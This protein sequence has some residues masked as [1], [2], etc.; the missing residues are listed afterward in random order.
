MSTPKVYQINEFPNSE[1]KFDII[2][3]EGCKK[4]WKDILSEEKSKGAVGIINLGYFVLSTG[5]YASDCKIHDKWMLHKNTGSYGI[6]IDKDGNAYVGTGEDANAYSY[7]EAVPA[8]TV[9]GKEMNRD[10][11]WS[12]NGTT[13]LGF[14]DG[15]LVCMLCDKDNGQS[16][17]NQIAS[18]EEYGCDTILRMD[19][20]WSSHGKLGYGKN[21]QPSQSRKDRFYLVIYDKNYK[22]PRTDKKV[23]LDPFGNGSD[24]DTFATCKLLKAL[25]EDVEGIE[26]M[27]SR[28]EDN[29]DLDAS[30]RADQA[31]Q[32]GA[33]LVYS[34]STDATGDVDGTSVAW[35]NKETSSAYKFAKSILSYMKEAGMSVSE[36]PGVLDTL[37]ILKETSACAALAL[38][39]GDYSTNEAR[40]KAAVISAKAI[41]NQLG[42][43]YIEDD[44]VD[45]PTDEPDIEESTTVNK[46]DP[47]GMYD[48]ETLDKFMELKKIGLIDK[49]AQ[50]Q[51]RVRYGDIL[52]ALFYSIQKIDDIEDD[53]SED[54]ED[55]TP[56]LT[57]AVDEEEL[58]QFI[59]NAVTEAINDRLS[60]SVDDAIT[61]KLDKINQASEK[62]MDDI[63]KKV[64]EFNDLYSKKVEEFSKTYTSVVEDLSNSTSSVMN[65]LKDSLQSVVDS[66]I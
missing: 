31:N 11:T 40:Y 21:V 7:A 62:A 49:D 26:C 63:G 6:C 58:K 61:S 14:K 57:P 41:C 48:Q 27:I 59:I 19:G 44:T 3:N 32:W 1:Y 30:I 28:Y 65:K 10:Q 25:L 42:V 5:N 54:I 33:N 17:A 4:S 38:F 36:T 8:Y 12:A 50:I 9:N 45:T 56:E 16:T 35:T 34:I 23:T 43:E 22:A 51:E 18:M 39:V 15:N 66:I 53:E 64:D 2:D 37:P 20:S 52:D 46:D 55:D 60:T 29:A 47:Y 24:V 13:T